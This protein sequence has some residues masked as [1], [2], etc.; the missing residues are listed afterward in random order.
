VNA[1]EPFC[2]ARSPLAPAVGWAVFGGRRR[3]S[4]Q[5]R[6]AQAQFS[7]PPQRP[8]CPCRALLP[9]SF[10]VA[11]SCGVVVLVPCFGGAAR[12]VG[13]GLSVLKLAAGAQRPAPHRTVRP[14]P[15]RTTHRNTR[16]QQGKGDGGVLF[17]RAVVPS[18]VSLCPR[19]SAPWLL[20]LSGVCSARRFGKSP[21][22]GG[23]FLT[24]T[25]RRGSVRK[26]NEE[27]KKG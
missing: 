22:R 5:D 26:F 24:R 21:T 8:G 2:C 20:E 14:G 12:T 7:L 27:G 23:V 6:L 11:V 25:E 17:V 13:F 19:P 15:H 3:T 4:E 1:P 10:L 18:V 16:T 9:S